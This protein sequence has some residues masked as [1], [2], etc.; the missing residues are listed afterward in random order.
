MWDFLQHNNRVVTDPPIVEIKTV[1]QI[2][3]I[4]PRILKTKQTKTE[5]L[6]LFSIAQM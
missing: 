1:E 2:P 5:M 6:T 3:Y 4:H